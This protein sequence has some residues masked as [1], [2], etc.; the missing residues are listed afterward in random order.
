MAYIVDLTISYLNSEAYKLP[1]CTALF[2]TETAKTSPTPNIPAVAPI[3][4]NPTPSILIAPTDT[5]VIGNTQ[6]LNTLIWSKHATYAFIVK[7]TAPVYL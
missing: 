4:T 7:W 6:S 1:T 3:D 2:A 5:A